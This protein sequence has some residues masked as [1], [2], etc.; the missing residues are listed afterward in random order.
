ML[1]V[2][3]LNDDTDKIYSFSM[4]NLKFK[5]KSIQCVEDFSNV[6][7]MNHK[8]IEKVRLFQIKIVGKLPWWYRHAAGRRE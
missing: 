4:V 2:I 6:V 5:L 8:L 3:H 1:T 7:V